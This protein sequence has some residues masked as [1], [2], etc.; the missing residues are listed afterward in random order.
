MSKNIIKFKIFK[1]CPEI[2][3]GASTRKLGNVRMGKKINTENLI[4]ISKELK[5][6]F[7]NIITMKQ[8]HSGRIIFVQDLSK[9][10]YENI[11]GLITDKKDFFLG[12]I[13]ADC[14]PIVF[15]DP[16]KKIIGVVHAGYRGIF[17]G[18]IEKMLENFKKLGCDM[19]NVMVGIGPAIGVCCYNID[20]DRT[21][22]FRKK[23]Y[24]YTD[25]LVKRGKD[26]FLDLKRIAKIVLL[27]YG[28]S[29]DNL[30]IVPICTKCSL[31]NFFSYRG[32]TKVTFGEF[33]TV[34]GR[35]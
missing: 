34:I 7:E 31:D 27:E 12:V 10:I 1:S 5:I 18:I 8:I 20:P 25:I 21:K 13:T 29:E 17:E 30:E 11:D 4:K 33:I 16:L 26:W 3:S 23:Y 32:D 24:Q 19:K 6:N 14:L 15:Y 28:I 35:R 2:I 22:V 9:N